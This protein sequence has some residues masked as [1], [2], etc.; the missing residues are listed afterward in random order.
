MSAENKRDLAVFILLVIFFLVGFLILGWT[1]DQDQKVNECY[2]QHYKA[3]L[4]EM[5]NKETN[6]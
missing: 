6:E 4:K 2:I 3:E 1:F 5:Q